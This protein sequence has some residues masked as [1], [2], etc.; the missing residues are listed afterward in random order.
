MTGSPYAPVIAGIT[1]GIAFIILFSFQSNEQNVIAKQ[2]SIVTIPEG[3]AGQ[4]KNF[5]PPIIKVVI[6][7]NNTVRWMN[8]ESIPYTVVSDDD[9][10]DP[11]SGPFST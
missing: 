10:V 8:E 5:E 11:Q 2:V 4:D 3:V 9:Y 6:G 7:L 1:V